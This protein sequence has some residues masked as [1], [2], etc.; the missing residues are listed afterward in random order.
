[1]TLRRNPPDIRYETYDEFID[2]KGLVI[3]I[4]P[5]AM[6]PASDTLD[7]PRGSRHYEVLIRRQ[8]SPGR[9]TIY[10]SQGPGVRSEPSPTDILNAVALDMSSYINFQSADDLAMEY[11]MEPREA[12][13]V[14]KALAKT[15][16]Q[17][18]TML[19]E[20]EIEELVYSIAEEL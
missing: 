20:D 14:Y 9:A 1:M 13:R 15:S 19:G 7:M 10:Y 3:T 6:R 5:I 18:S 4:R 16:R 8:G 2:D 17:L 12:S 11:A